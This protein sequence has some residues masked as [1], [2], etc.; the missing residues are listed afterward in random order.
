MIR[1]RTGWT[2]RE[3]GEM[4]LTQMRNVLTGGVDPR[5]RI[6]TGR[7]MKKILERF[8]RGEFK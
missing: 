7:A 5:P 1:A 8:K 2:Y 4:S 3:I 6:A